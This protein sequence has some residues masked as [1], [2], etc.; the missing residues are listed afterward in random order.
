LKGWRALPE[1]LSSDEL[2]GK[3]TEEEGSDSS[4]EDIEEDDSL[5]SNGGDG[6]SVSKKTSKVMPANII[7]RPWGSKREYLSSHYRL[8]REDVVAPLREALTTY[9]NNPAMSDDKDLCV[10]IRVSIQHRWHFH[11]LR[12]EKD[13]Y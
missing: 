2:M 6:H 3:N 1:I 7:D 4:D 5:E 9:R 11:F 12:K 13:I 10:Y 8:L